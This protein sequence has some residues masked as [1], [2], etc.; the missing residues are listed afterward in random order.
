MSAVSQPEQREALEAALDQASDEWANLVSAIRLILSGERDKER[1]HGQLSYKESMIV[2]AI[3]AK[4]T[5]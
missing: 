2:D 1:L 3:L 5:P 4:L